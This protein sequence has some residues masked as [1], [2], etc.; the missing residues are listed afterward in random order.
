M[1]RLWPALLTNE[2]VSLILLVHFIAAREKRV[3]VNAVKPQ[4]IAQVLAQTDL[5]TTTTTQL[6][7]Q[8][9]MHLFTMFTLHN[10][11]SVRHSPV[12]PT[13]PPSDWTRT[14]VVMLLALRKWLTICPF[15]T[16]RESTSML[17]T[18]NTNDGTQLR[19]TCD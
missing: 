8:N 1:N 6:R 19:S 2:R 13:Q 9:I 14:L 4:H 18:L 7:Q 12:K 16:T 3:G 5:Q 17:L 11:D 15:L 10:H